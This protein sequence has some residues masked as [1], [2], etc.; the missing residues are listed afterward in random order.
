M[1]EE[2]LQHAR[3]NAAR[4]ARALGTTERVVRYK[5]SKYGIDCT[6]FR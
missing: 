5:A 6:R 1:L 3:G 2:A 4:A